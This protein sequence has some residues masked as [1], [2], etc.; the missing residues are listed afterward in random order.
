[1]ARLQAV[2]RTVVQFPTGARDFI[3]W[4]PPSLLFNGYQGLSLSPS[5]NRPEHGA[6]HS[7]PSSAEVKNKHSYTPNPPYNL[8]C[9][10][11]LE[12]FIV[13]HRV[14]EFPNFMYP[15]GLLP[16]LEKPVIGPYSPS[17]KFSQNPK[18]YFS[19]IQFNIILLSSLFSQMATSPDIYLVMRY[20]PLPIYFTSHRSQHYLAC[21]RIALNS[22]HLHLI[23]TLLPP[24][25]SFH[26][27]FLLYLIVAQ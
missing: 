8:Q 21:N 15:K 18:F 4:G 20:P 14:K 26:N 6:D 24:R 5:V 7:P 27:T 9:E 3:F 12:E 11:N 13:N 16:S 17:E 23:L 10:V 22:H 2:W 1:V 19:E 25:L